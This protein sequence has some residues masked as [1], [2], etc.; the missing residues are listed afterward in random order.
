MFVVWYGA[1]GSGQLRR[2]YRSRTSSLRRRWHGE[3]NQSLSCVTE[4]S[5]LLAFA[6][7]LPGPSFMV[8]RHVCSRDV[9][10][11]WSPP[12]MQDF[13]ASSCGGVERVTCTG[14]LVTAEGRRDCAPVSRIFQESTA[15][16]SI[17]LVVIFI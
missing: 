2:S 7:A 11:A 8:L 10:S 17:V 13:R 1:S 9:V 15:I 4:T 3:L 14:G 12:R 5:T 6:K 16:G